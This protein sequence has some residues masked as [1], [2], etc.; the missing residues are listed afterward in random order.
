MH[1]KHWKWRHRYRR[2]GNMNAEEHR[3]QRVNSLMAQVRSAGLGDGYGWSMGNGR[4]KF[5]PSDVP[6]ICRTG[7][8]AMI[9]QEGFKE[10]VVQCRMLS[11]T[12]DGNPIRMP[13]TLTKCSSF[14]LLERTESVENMLD[15]A[16]LVG[17]RPGIWASEFDPPAAERPRPGFA[18][19]RAPA[20][21]N[22]E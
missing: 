5:A 21:A 10:P 20:P 15:R 9:M 2:V 13:T 1:I 4:D 8:H 3:Q 14:V 12:S 17:P 7:S 16:L 19:P 11:S 6:G 18:A 22:G